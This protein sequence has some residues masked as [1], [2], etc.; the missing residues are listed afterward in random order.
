MPSN[1]DASFSTNGSLPRS[2]EVV[3]IRGGV[4]GAATARQ[5]TRRGVL[6]VVLLERRQLG[7]GASGKSGA[8]VRCHYAN[9]HEARLAAES[10]KV[11][12]GWDDLVGHGDPGFEP[13]GFVQLVAP[14]DEANL[15]AN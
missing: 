15:R 7:A 8:L 1:M 14:E 5:L 12:R 10:V 13:T 9:P 2:A 6:N 3:G 4:S 11:F